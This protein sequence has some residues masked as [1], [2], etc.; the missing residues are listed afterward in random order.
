MTVLIEDVFP[1]GVTNELLD[2]VTDEMGVDAGLPPGGIMHVHFE[3]DG[4]AHGVDCGTRSRL[5]S[6]SSSQRLCQPWAR[7]PWQEAST[8]QRWANPK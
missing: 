5:M 7:L 8:R 2:A 3:K 6:S 1:V 4:R